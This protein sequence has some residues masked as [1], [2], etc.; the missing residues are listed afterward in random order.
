MH[1]RLRHALSAESVQGPK[2]H[3]IKFPLGG[4]LE[5][6]G[7]LLALVRALP[8]AFGFNVFPDDR[9]AGVGA[10]SPQFTELVL[11]VLALIES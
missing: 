3:A 11:G 8:A 7:E 2:Q 10:P 9:V 4:I 5:Q 1:N 6:S